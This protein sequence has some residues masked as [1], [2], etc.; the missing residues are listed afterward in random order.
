MNRLLDLD[1][2]LATTPGITDLKVTLRRDPVKGIALVSTREI[3]RGA[4]IAYYHMRVYS[5]ARPGPFGSTYRFAVYTKRATVSKQFVGN[6]FSGSLRAPRRNI[7]YW[8]YFANE[9]DCG[10]TANSFVDA[11]VAR[12]YRGRSRL[13]VGDEITYKL[14]A[15]RKIVPGEEIVWCYGDRYERD[16]A[17]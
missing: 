15:S 9:P 14:V 11:C 7:P 2:I 16:Y 3:K 8:A 4:V 17:V 6:L 1:W 5:I 13:R 12:N 10:N